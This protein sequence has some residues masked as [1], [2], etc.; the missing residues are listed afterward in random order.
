MPSGLY[1]DV[2]LANLSQVDAK[3]IK[4][5]LVIQERFMSINLGQI[6]IRIL[7]YS[8]VVLCSIMLMNTYM[9]YD[10]YDE[11]FTDEQDLLF[12]SNSA[13]HLNSLDRNI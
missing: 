12:S 6:Y 2:P 13:L 3:A 5:G 11:R 4:I 7:V 9:K 8:I 1:R 10:V